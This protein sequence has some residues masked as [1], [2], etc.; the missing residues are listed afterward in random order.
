MEE[1]KKQSLQD[2]FLNHLRK[3]KLSVTVYLI[4]GVR[5]K[6]VVKGFDNFVII[7]KEFSELLIYKHAISTI[8]P[9]RA[10]NIKAESCTIKL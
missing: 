3:E 2:S 1:N 6:G 9:E 4:S 7:L 5:L 10:V 8:V